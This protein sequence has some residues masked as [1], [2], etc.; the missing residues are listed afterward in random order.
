MKKILAI[1]LFTILISTGCSNS[2]LGDINSNDEFVKVKVT[3]HVDGDT[4]YVMDKSNEEYKLR[5]IG[6][7]TPETKHPT[8]G[9]EYFGKEASEFTK[10]NLLDKKIYLERDVSNKDRYGRYLRYIW[11]SLPSN[12]KNISNSEV[13]NNMFNAIL[14]KE[15]Y[16]N[17]STFPPDVKYNEYFL[18]L[19]R[20]AKE[21]KKGLW[22]SYNYIGNKNSKKFH[23]P[24]C[25]YAEKIKEDNKI[26]FDKRT[27]AIDKGYEPGGYCKP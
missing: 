15:G 7:D 14:I 20:S 24:D 3:K 13:K 10:E 8:I 18:K 26:Y 17:A 2:D 22:E 25:P 12:S 6:V 11:L 27:E 4:V 23:L 5:F 1:F 21:N 16:A 9:V 19:Q